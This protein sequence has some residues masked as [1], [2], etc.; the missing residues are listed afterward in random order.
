MQVKSGAKFRG[1][2][3]IVVLDRK[4]GKVISKSRCENILTDE[5]LNK[6]LNVM[7]HGA[8]QINPWYCVMFENDVTPGAGAT[9][10]VPTYIETVAYT[11]GAR[12]EY[13]EAESTA[14]STTNLANQ[15][16]FTMS[17]FVGIKTLFGAAL[18][19]GGGSPTVK[20]NVAGGGTLLSA[21]RFDAA[22]PIISGNVVSLIYK[23][24]DADA[25]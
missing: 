18:V 9:Y 10:A 19:G 12:P 8:T 6:L 16:I 14:K 23:I 5:G 24:T 13:N 3:E 25:P 7:L 15:A 22:Q 4:G 17:G 1:V 11:E 21:G 20:G 2:W